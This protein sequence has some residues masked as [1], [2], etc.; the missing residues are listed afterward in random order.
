MVGCQWDDE[1]NLY[2]EKW[3]EITVSIH[4][5]VVVQLVVLTHLKNINQSN[6]IIST[7]KGE[8]KTYLKPPPSCLELQEGVS[9]NRGTHIFGNI[10]LEFQEDLISQESSCVMFTSHLPLKSH[11]MSSCPNEQVTTQK[12]L[13][14]SPCTRMSQEYGKWLVNGLYNLLIHVI[15]QG[16]NPLILTPLTSFQ[17]D[18]QVP[19]A[20]SP[21]FLN[22]RRIFMLKKSLL[23]SV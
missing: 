19:K 13:G 9:K 18:I 1:P 17:R 23:T 21:W 16:Y 5:K 2:M 4:Q 8:H 3:L 22:I 6:W 11:H 10:R 14:K 20:S 12:F 15:Y 7:G